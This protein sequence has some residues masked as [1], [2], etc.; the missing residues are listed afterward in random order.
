MTAAATKE[1]KQ[2]RQLLYAQGHHAA[3][4]QDIGSISFSTICKH[5]VFSTSEH[6]FSTTNNFPFERW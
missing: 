6:V 4:H 2:L 3:A 1:Q 5:T